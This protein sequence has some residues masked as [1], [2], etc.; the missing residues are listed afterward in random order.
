MINGHMIRCSA[1]QIIRE[2]QIKTI[3][4]FFQNSHGSEWPSSKTLQIVNAGE[5]VEKR[6]TSYAVSGN[7][8]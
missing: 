6:E 5:G 3:M 1:L 7:V 4:R 2:M 8:N